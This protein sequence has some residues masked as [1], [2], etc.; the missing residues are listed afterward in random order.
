MNRFGWTALGLT[1]I[2][3]GCGYGVVGQ[4]D[5]LPKDIKTIAIPAFGNATT[6]YT[7]A[8]SLPAD[9]TREFISRTHY[10]IV[11]NP[12]AADAV[13]KGT[14][15]RYSSFGTTLDPNTGRASSAAIGATI[16]LSLTDRAT[17]K[18]IYSRTFEEHDHY[19]V[20]PDTRTYFEESGAA[21]SRI[22]RT[23]AHNVV[24][25]ILEKF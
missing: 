25:A 22:S 13:L 10:R 1:L 18:V 14:I 9:I 23:V 15:I 7:L 8:D 3:F 12:D 20:S 24:S 17:G 2:S 21:L 19:E 5:T 11:T 4:T 16:A 6:L